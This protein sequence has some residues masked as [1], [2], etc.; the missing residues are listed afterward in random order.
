[1]LVFKTFKDYSLEK[2]EKD[3]NDYLV[4][5]HIGPADIKDFKVSHDKDLTE[6]CVTF[7]HQ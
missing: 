1:M 4:K 6:F 2:I 7:L 5:N 3:V